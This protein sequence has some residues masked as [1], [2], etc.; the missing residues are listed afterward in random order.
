MSQCFTASGS[1][2]IAGLQ[3]GGPLWSDKD[4]LGVMLHLLLLNASVLQGQL[5]A[6]GDAEAVCARVGH[7]VGVAGDGASQVLCRQGGFGLGG[8]SSLGR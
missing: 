1:K 3:T 8:A 7:V 4:R 6:G 2:W 5:D